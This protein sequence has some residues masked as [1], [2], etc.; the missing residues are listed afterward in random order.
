MLASGVEMSNLTP[1]RSRR[2]GPRAVGRRGRLSLWWAWA[3]RASPPRSK[4]GSEA[5]AVV[6]LDR[7]EGGGA[8]AISGGVFYAGGGT[9]IQKEAGVEDTV[10]NMYRYSG[11]G[12]AGRGVRGDSSRLLR[13]ERRQREVVDGPWCSRSCPTS[14]QSRP[15]TQRTN[16][17]STTPGNETF[18]PYS[19]RAKPAQRGHRADG[20]AFP[21][22]NIV[23][24]LR[25]DRD[26]RRRA[27]SASVP[28][29]PADRQ[30][31]RGAWSGSSINIFL[32]G[33]GAPCID[34][35]T[36]SKW[37]WGSSSPAS[38]G[39]CESSATRSSASTP[40]LGA[41]DAS[42]AWCWPQAASSTTERW[43]PSTCPTSYRVSHLAPRA[44]TAWGFGWGKAWAVR[45]TT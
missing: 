41:F 9:H 39:G 35:C 22:F 40:R 3:P 19:E 42:T 7:F 44:T 23:E 4:P 6:V 12:G 16:T 27:A 25:R 14:V 2:C 26:P 11:D 21:G 45:S 37:R 29:Q 32:L 43:S 24:P 8:T 5:A 38:L 36:V 13:D 20:G 30:T 31:R 10:E 28:R 18:P 17:T 33:S 15:R 34:G 1:T